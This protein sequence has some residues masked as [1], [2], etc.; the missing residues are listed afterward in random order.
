LIT[1][2][3]ASSVL[4]SSP[5][6]MYVA[7]PRPIAA[8]VAADS[9][10]VRPSVT[11]VAIGVIAPAT[12]ARVAVPWLP[13]ASLAIACRRFVPGVTGML[14][15]NEPSLP[16]GVATPL[17]VSEVAGDGAAGGRGDGDARGVRIDGRATGVV[18]VIGAGGDEG[19]DAEADEFEVAHIESPVDGE[20]FSK[21]EATAS[22]H[23]PCAGASA[24]GTRPSLRSC[25]DTRVVWGSRD[26]SASAPPVATGYVTRMTTIG[27]PLPGSMPN[28][29]STESGIRG[30]PSSV[31]VNG[32]SA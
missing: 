5:L 16:T 28:F 2:L 12:T 3:P 7:A 17:I 29:A 19:R 22:N 11:D 30:L 23:L 24:A 10:A 25:Q 32:D 27:R 31:S 15:L 14:A 6:V 1:G 9:S 8:N 20:T 26:A 21:K 4:A 18:R 13:A